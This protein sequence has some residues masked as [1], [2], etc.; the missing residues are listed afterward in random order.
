M[1]LRDKVALVTGAG[2][3]IGREIALLMAAHGAKVVVNDLGGSAKGDGTDR[4]PAEEVAREI[5]KAGGEAVANFDTVSTW[6]SAHAM[7]EQAID[8]W[9]KIDIVVNNAGILRDRMF[10]KM[11]EEEWDAVL[12][13]HVKGHFCVTR[14]AINQMKE[15]GFGRV[16]NFTS[17]SGLIGNIGQTNYGAAKMAVVGLTRNLAL[18][19]QRYGVTVNAISPFAWTRMIGTIPTETD[20]QKA[21]VEKIKQMSPA[22]VAPLAVFLASDAAAGISGQIFGVRAKEIILFSLPRP[23]RTLGRAEGWTPE[24]LAEIIPGTFESAFSPLRVSAQEF[25]HDPLV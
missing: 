1:M 2:R 5:E 6:K 20:A 8:R 3:G 7:V 18:E 23:V 17:T 15:K 11:S 24:D 12:D 19:M 13:V 25:P 14:A 21:R 10:W 22:H 16:I 9:G 4:G